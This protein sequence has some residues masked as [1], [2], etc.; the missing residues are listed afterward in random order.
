MEVDVHDELNGRRPRG[1]R[2]RGLYRAARSVA[3]CVGICAPAPAF[4]IT[5]NVTHS[6]PSVVGE[7][8]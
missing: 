7:A 2:T 6:G 8:H 5:L 3:V 1:N 4:A